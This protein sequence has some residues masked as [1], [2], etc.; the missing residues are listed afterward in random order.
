[1]DS[2]AQKLR[3]PVINGTKSDIVKLKKIRQNYENCMSISSDPEYKSIFAG[4]IRKID[5]IIKNIEENFNAH[6]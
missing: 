6:Q 5:R 3:L 1:M 4:M 2:L